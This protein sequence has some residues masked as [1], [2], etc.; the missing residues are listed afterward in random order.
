MKVRA[1]DTETTIGDIGEEVSPFRP[2]IWVVAH[3]WV[4][5]EVDADL[6]PTTIHDTLSGPSPLGKATAR[7]YTERPEDGWLAEVLDGCDLMVM[8]NGSYD[9]SVALHH[10]PKNLDAY[11]AWVNRGGRIWDVLQAEYTLRGAHSDVQML[12]LDQVCVKYGGRVKEDQVKAMWAAGV[13]TPDIPRHILLDY[14]RGTM[15]R[16]EGHPGDIG[17]T[18]LSYLGQVKLRQYKAMAKAIAL[19]MMAVQAC[20]EMARNGIY[21]DQQMGEELRVDAIARMEAAQAE[22]LTFIPEEHQ[23]HINPNSRSVKSAVLFGGDVTYDVRMYQARD[24]RE[25]LEPFPVDEQDYPKKT[26]KVPMINEDGT[27]VLYKSGKQMGE[28]KY[29]NESVPDT[30]KD[31]KYRIRQVTFALP[32]RVTPPE[33]SLGDD[34]IYSTASQVLDQI[35]DQDPAITAMREL[36]MWTK[37]VGTSYWKLDSKGNKKGMMSRIGPDGLIHPSFRMNTTTT[38]RMS[39]DKPNMQQTSKKSRVKEALQSRHGSAGSI[40]QADFQSLESF[41]VALLTGDP[42]TLRDLNDPHFDMHCAAVAFFKR[43]TVADAIAKCKGDN[44]DPEWKAL[45]QT[46]KGANFAYEYGAGAVTIARTADISLEEAQRFIEF[47]EQLYPTAVKFERDLHTSVNANVRYTGEEARDPDDPRFTY[48]RGYG[49]YRGVTGRT[50]AFELRPAGKAGR[51]AGV[52]ESVPPTATGNFPFQGTG[53][54]WAKAAIAIG[55]RMSCLDQ[56]PARMIAVVHDAIYADCQKINEEA[57]ARAVA[58]CMHYSNDVVGYLG[59]DMKARVPYSL[60]HGP[61]WGEEHELHVEPLALP[62]TVQSIFE[63]AS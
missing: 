10:Y 34:G 31:P 63:Y 19:D 21:M 32:R 44:A 47:R 48:R 61:S 40:V 9:L 41:V 16:Q 1:W 33:G 45:R 3:A 42:A 52:T 57:T 38:Q 50:W 17:N 23:P 49:Y 5:T 13:N 39:C 6:N 12:S 26:I 60:G 14:L 54:D 30:D 27:P 28:Q 51:K 22:F 8:A 43:C 55:F 4:D 62:F 11:K 36:A 53:A 25:A 35:T 59:V 29:R 46:M 20:E 24:G 2:G 15:D 18:M 56:F 58:T 37:D 7:Y